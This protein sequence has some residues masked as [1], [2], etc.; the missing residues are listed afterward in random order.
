FPTQRLFEFDKWLSFFWEREVQLPTAY[1]EHITAFHGGV[2]GKKC[3]ATLSGEARVLCRFFNFLELSD[4]RPPF[5]KSWRSWSFG[6]DI[7]LN[8]RVRSYFDNEFWAFQLAER[9]K[10]LKL[11]PIAGLAT[12][13]HDCREAEEYDL[14]CLDYG[15]PGEPP[16]V[17]WQF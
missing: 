11:L 13:G 9:S 15:L 1:K 4:L 2:P 12:A 6:P 5:T 7:R 17:T 8:Y 14:L 16:V 3:F 10:G